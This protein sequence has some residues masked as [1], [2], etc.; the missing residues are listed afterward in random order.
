MN[1]VSSSGLWWGGLLVAG[2][3]LWL[4]D[5]TDYISISPFVAATFFALAGIG[6]AID[7]SRDPGSWWAAIPAGALLGLGA[8]ITF[9]EG[10][11]APDE[12]GA[13]LL[14]AGSGLGFAGA[15]VRVREHWWAL[16]PAG[17]LVSVA[18]I[19]ASVPIVERG[20]GIAVVVLGIMAAILVVLAFVPIRGRRLFWPL[21][22]AAMLGLVA[23]FLAQDSVETLEQF[24]WVSPAVL[25]VIGLFI[26]FRALANRGADREGH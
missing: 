4:V 15:Y 11:T 8:L 10:T 16:I 24:N 21:V 23:V 19:V 2:G 1:R 26:V 17:L 18:I 14:L 6:F 9:V 20:E 3:A 25:L 22:P 13:S 12:W 7:F 5:A